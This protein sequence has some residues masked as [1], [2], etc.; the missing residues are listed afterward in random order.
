MNTSE[1][2]AEDESKHPN[3]LKNKEELD[4]TA[5]SE[6]EGVNLNN[7]TTVTWTSDEKE[8]LKKELESELKELDAAER[9]NHEDFINFLF[10]KFPPKHHSNPKKPEVQSQNFATLKRALVKL[11]A[12]YHPD[13]VDPSLHG[14]KHKVLCEE[15]AKRVNSRYAKLKAE[16]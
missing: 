8:D 2:D 10:R 11:T 4:E 3:I 14:E 7:M 5:K 1:E 12:Y 9:L 15:I 16:N 6:E 13:K